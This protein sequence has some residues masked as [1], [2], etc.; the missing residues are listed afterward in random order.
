MWAKNQHVLDTGRR[1]GLTWFPI[2]VLF[3]GGAQR[4]VNFGVGSK[5]TPSIQLVLNGNTRMFRRA[6]LTLFISSFLFLSPHIEVSASIALPTDLSLGDQFRLVFVTSTKRDATSPDI[7]DY[8]DFVQDA[9]DASPL[10]VLNQTWVAI[11]STAQ[12]D[13]RDNTE[14]NPNTDGLGVPIYLVDGTRIADDYSDLWDSTLAAPIGITEYGL[15][16]PI[17]VFGRTEVWTGSVSQGI[18]VSVIQPS[19]EPLGGTLLQVGTGNAGKTDFGWLNFAALPAE[20]ADLPLYA[21]S[22]L[23]TVGE[24]SLVPEPTAFIVWSLLGL[25]TGCTVWL[26]K[27]ADAIE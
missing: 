24:Q 10:A 2:G 15:S 19:R 8:N 1:A 26:R 25:T 14:S 5:L 11:A 21:M 20:Y 3:V 16:V 27:P 7:D 12:I 17:N 6:T 22:G 13:A 23:L 9:A 18:D 4:N